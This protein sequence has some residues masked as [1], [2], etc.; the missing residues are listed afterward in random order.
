MK[1][2]K[3]L[4]FLLLIGLTL[5]TVTSC[6]KDEGKLPDISFKT[7]GNYISSDVT[8]PAGSAI[9]IGINAAKTEDKDVLKKFNVSKAINGGAPASV[10]SK[11]LSG[12]EGDQYSTDYTATLE[13]TPGQVDQFIFTVTNR[14]GLTNQVAVK[15]TIQ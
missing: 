10:F 13:T 6:E 15:I 5:F 3:P 1:F 11:D 9:I 7:G 2:A 8:L 12:S 14:D 4:L